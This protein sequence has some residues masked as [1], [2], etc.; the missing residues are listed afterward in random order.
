MTIC[1]VFGCNHQG[2]R[3]TCKMFRFPSNTG[4]AKKWEK[5]CSRMDSTLNVQGDRICDC[6]FKNRKK[7]NGP[8]IFPWSSEKKLISRILVKLDGLRL[9]E[10]RELKLKPLRCVHHHQL[11]MR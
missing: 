3:R 2:L 6:H 7:E 9:R 1:F 5:F 11:Q 10:K 8:T 4:L